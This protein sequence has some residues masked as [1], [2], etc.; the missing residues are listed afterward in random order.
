MTTDNPIDP[1]LPPTGPI[2]LPGGDP[3]NLPQHNIP[4]DDEEVV[5]TLLEE[6]TQIEES[7]DPM[8]A[9]HIALVHTEL[10]IA[11]SMQRIADTLED[12]ISA[13]LAA[14]QDDE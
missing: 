9:T 10:W 2:D 4:T 7:A 12:L 8:V 14:D 6:I 5:L 3:L 11:R 1:P 13:Y